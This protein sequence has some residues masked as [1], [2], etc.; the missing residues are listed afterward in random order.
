M[1]DCVNYRH[2]FGLLPL[3]KHEA[4][5]YFRHQD[6]KTQK[7]ISTKTLPL[8]FRPSWHYFSGLTDLAVLLFGKHTV[9][10]QSVTG[11]FISQY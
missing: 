6:P 8:C 7:W 5:N 2:N 10:R 3:L 9:V 11:F 1:L 4:F